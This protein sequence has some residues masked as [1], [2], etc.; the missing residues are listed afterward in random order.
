MTLSTGFLRKRPVRSR[1]LAA[2]AA[3][4]LAA[5]LGGCSSNPATGKEDIVFMSPSDEKRIGDEN[6]PHILR[7]FGGAYDDPKLQ[8]YVK[9]LGD[10]L[11]AS[12]EL[13]NIKWTFTLLD[14]EITNA[15]ALPGGYVYVTRGLV[16][17]AESEAQL[18][19]V[20]GHE[21]GHVTARHS[22]QRHAQGTFAQVGAIG[23]SILGAVLVGPEAGRAIGQTATIGAHAY[24]A[25]Y[26]R[27]QEYEAD[28][29]G[30]RYN[31]RVGFAPD[32][33]AGF[34][35]KLQAEKELAAKLRGQ[36]PRGS[37]YFDTHPPTPDR[38]KRATKLAAQT[39]VRDPID[40]RDVFLKKIDG[41]IWGDSPDQGYARDGVFAHEGLNIRYEVPSDFTLFNTPQKVLAFGPGGSA[42][43]FD[44]GPKN[45]GGTMYDYLRQTWGRNSRLSNLE[46]ITV[47]GLEGATA[48]TSGTSNGQ[49]V[50]ARLVAIKGAKGDT[51]RL[52]FISPTGKTASLANG[53]R[54][55]AYSF[56]HLSAAE[57]AKLGPWRIRLYKVRRGD[58]ADSIASRRM[59]MKK[60]AK[61]RFMLLNGLSANSTLT[62]GRLVKVVS[63][64]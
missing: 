19:A 56:R 39:K 1:L 33:M 29:L 45:Y 53:F 10:V 15:F 36:T 11:A 35:A 61:E 12:S 62:P 18:A 30:I 55:T 57:R 5:S 32:G 31:G 28:T 25:S 14:S 54:E 51:F 40:G 48:T 24:V 27:S 38:V 42:I 44:T 43:I 60:F 6:H 13:P 47:N 22:A 2:L 34:L 49:K 20:I 4:A 52:V 37:S 17:L 58:T 41:M 26:S 63:E 64:R 50:D 9:S 46:R 8:A 3:A 7:E 23:A 16:S 59:A 21:I